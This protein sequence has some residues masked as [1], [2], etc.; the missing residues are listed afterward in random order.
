MK[1]GAVIQEREVCCGFSDDS[2][3]V[4]VLQVCAHSREVF[5]DRYSELFE[6]GGRTYTAELENLRSVK[7]FSPEM[8]TSRVA[9]TLPSVPLVVEALLLGSAR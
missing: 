8:M 2:H 9:L 5:D 1:I 3:L 7:C 6:L 4:P